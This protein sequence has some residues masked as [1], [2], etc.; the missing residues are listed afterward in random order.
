MSVFALRCSLSA[1]ALR[2]SLS[3]VSRPAT[4]S[5]HF[6]L[7]LDESLLRGSSQP[8]STFDNECLASCPDFDV[9]GVELWALLEH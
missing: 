6:G 8:C 5:G 1:F 7:L 4:P 9:E 3:A 2:C